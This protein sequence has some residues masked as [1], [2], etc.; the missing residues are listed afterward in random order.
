MGLPNIFVKAVLY[1]SYGSQP[2][3]ASRKFEVS[4]EGAKNT[5]S[6]VWNKVIP[7]TVPNFP[8][9]LDLEIHDRGLRDEEISRVR[10]NFT[11]I[12]GVERN[13]AGKSMMFGLD[14]KYHVSITRST[15]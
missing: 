9:M 11:Y 4:T 13:F 1:G 15:D 2:G 12:P 3:V 5:Q 10:L 8:K 14:G 6:P 7:L